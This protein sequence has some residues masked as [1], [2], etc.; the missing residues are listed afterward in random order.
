[1]PTMMVPLSRGGVYAQTSAGPVQFGIPPETIK[2]SMA[3]DLEVPQYYVVPHEP[4]D[5]RRALN[6]SEFEFPAYYNFFVLKRKIVLIDGRRLAQL[7]IDHDIGVA[8]AR[9]FIL[10]KVDL[11]Y[12][13][14]DG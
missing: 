4:F 9:S 2:D 12:F 1:M 3:L 10:K 7:M 8:T 14:E 5:R 11:D 6:V 13:D